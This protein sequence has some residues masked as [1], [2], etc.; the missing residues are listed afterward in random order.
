MQRLVSQIMSAFG[1]VYF[2]LC[3]LFYVYSAI[4]L[5]IIAKK[6]QTSNAW[7]AWI[8]GVNIFLQCSIAQRSFIWAIIIFL[9]PSITLFMGG[10]AFIIG[11]LVIIILMFIVWTDIASVC[12]KPKWLII[13]LFLPLGWFIFWGYLAFTKIS[14]EEKEDKDDKEDKEEKKEIPEKPSEPQTKEDD[15]PDPPIYND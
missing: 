13:L 2:I 4:T 10:A 12:S 8:P 5:Q 6:T 15:E 3:I 11:I 14:F 9:L 7:L 1:I